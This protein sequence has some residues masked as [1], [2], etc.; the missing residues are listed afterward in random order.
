MQKY[1]YY[2][3]DY[4]F[5][6]SLDGFIDLYKTKA[7]HTPTPKDFGITEEDI[8]IYREYYS[9]GWEYEL[10]YESIKGQ[11]SWMASAICWAVFLIFCASDPD[12]DIPKAEGN[13]EL[14]AACLCSIFLI[15][16]L[17]LFLIPAHNPFVKNPITSYFIHRHVSKKYKKTRKIND[18]KI[19]AGVQDYKQAVERYQNTYKGIDRYNNNFKE[20]I[21]NEVVEKIICAIINQIKKEN[22]RIQQYNKGVQK[23][24]DSAVKRTKWDDEGFWYGLDPYAFE[25]EVAKWFIENGYKATITPKSGDGGVDIKITNEEGRHFYVQ[26]KRYCKQKVGRPTLQQLYGIVCTDSNKGVGGGIIV[27]LQGLSPAAKDFAEQVNIKVYTVE[28]L[29]AKIIKKEIR[30]QGN[31]NIR[32]FKEL[33]SSKVIKVDDGYKVGHVTLI[34]NFFDNSDNAKQEWLT[35]ALKKHL[36]T[37]DVNSTNIDN[38]QISNIRVENSIQYNYYEYKSFYFLLHCEKN[39]GNEIFESLIKGR[40]SK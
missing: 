15:C 34:K 24:R 23:E 22:E 25:E 2:D 37:T 8:K 3:K 30:Q 35:L 39:T 4:I 13:L 38:S 19:I 17:M 7:I 9:V 1:H 32:D 10:H 11:L 18:G 21:E 26:C 16:F 29:S 40:K 6:K 28:D 31:T 14:I 12:I 36:N 27:C 5:I 20:W 33:I